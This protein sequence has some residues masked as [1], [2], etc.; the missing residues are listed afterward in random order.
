LADTAWL[1][2]DDPT[3]NPAFY[4][5]IE[6]FVK[7]IN[8]HGMLAAPILVW[9]CAPDDPGQYLSEEA[10]IQI[11]RYEMDR[12]KKH[13]VRWILAGDG[14]YTGDLGAKWRRIGRK[15][16]PPTRRIPVA[17]HLMGTTL[18]YK[19]LS[20]EPWLDIWGYQSGYGDDGMDLAW[21]HLGPVAFTWPENSKRVLSTWS[22]IMRG[23]PA[24]NRTSR[25]LPTMCAGLLTGAC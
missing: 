11:V 21:I 15:V 14:D 5:R 16:F 22:R 25:I 8:D 7:A 18:P 9:T 2:R 17:M 10:I 3:L 12:L 20:T 4:D 13:Q 24:A 23:I 6:K 1:G 19:E